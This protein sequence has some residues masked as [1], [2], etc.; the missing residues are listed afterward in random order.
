MFLDLDVIIVGNLDEICFTES[1]FRLAFDEKKKKSKIGNSSVFVFD[2][3][4][5]IDVLDN[6]NRNAKNILKTYRNEQ[7]YLSAVME[8]KGILSFFPSEWCPSFKYHCVPK[9]P[10]NFLFSPKIPVNSKN[11]FSL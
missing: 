3:M 9:F 1:S 10:L 4:T 11:P 6:F 7:A 8:E 2:A 5:H